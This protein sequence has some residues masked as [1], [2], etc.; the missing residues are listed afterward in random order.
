MRGPFTHAWTKRSRVSR[1]TIAIRTFNREVE[2]DGIRPKVTDA[3][4]DI[5]LREAMKADMA[6]HKSGLR[7]A[8]IKESR[9]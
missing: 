4:T 5:F 8:F 3:A 7:A 1:S 6:H 9:F 2:I